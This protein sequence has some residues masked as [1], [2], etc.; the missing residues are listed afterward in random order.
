MCYI[1]CFYLFILQLLIL[2][3]SLSNSNVELDQ[4]DDGR[5]IPSN[6]CPRIF[7]DKCCLIL[8]LQVC[9][10]YRVSIPPSLL[11]L[12]QGQS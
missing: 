9:K 7:A 10:F 1:I 12:S 3:L 11:I 2:L 6:L 4:P 5:G 8:T